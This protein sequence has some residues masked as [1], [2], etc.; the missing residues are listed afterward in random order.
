MPRIVDEATTRTAAL[1]PSEGAAFAYHVLDEVC[2]R[3]NASEGW[4]V[5]HPGA[6][7]P[8]VF[9]R[10]ALPV[11]PQEARTLACL[12]TGV[13]GAPLAALPTAHDASIRCE[14]EFL[15]RATAAEAAAD[16]L[17][18]FATRRV[19]DAA[20]ARAAACAARYRWSTTAVLL[21][22]VGEGAPEERWHALACAL[23][24]ALRA[25]DE[26][27]I[28]SPGVAL[29]LLG[30]SGPDVVRP[31]VTR[32]RA[33]LSAGGSDGVDLLVAT[34]TTPQESVDPAELRHLAM[35]RLVTTGA[36]PASLAA[37]GALELDLRLLPGVVCVGREAPEGRPLLRVLTLT[38]S[39]ALR[40]TIR[41]KVR[42]WDPDVSVDVAAMSEAD[43]TGAPPVS[44]GSGQAPLQSSLPSFDTN[45]A[46]ATRA[47]VGA[48]GLRDS[49]FHGSPFDGAP[50]NGHAPLIGSA[51][52]ASVH[53]DPGEP[54]DP[55]PLL[56]ATAPGGGGGRRDERARIS[57]VSATFD[58]DR[59]MSEVT[60]SS[61]GVRG[62]GRAP[63]GPLAGGAQ[64]TLVALGA[65]GQDVPF[66][67][68]SAGRI[69]AVP[70]EPVVVVLAPRRAGE[71]ALSTAERIG[72]ATG[73]EDVEAAS[74]AAL[75]ALNRF[76]AAPTP[77][78]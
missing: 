44:S 54:D 31:F 4:M 28:D 8:Q 2:E 20:L 5:L 48:T 40:E 66:Y 27:G 51:D 35:G 69:L 10:G 12:P 52:M 17:S 56:A 72:I 9:R 78:A 68:V 62:T 75:S 61:A 58:P 71:G 59:G 21:T 60:L 53:P 67:L 41:E 15:E 18:G 32:V 38:S 33:C 70:G 24:H 23:R 37:E 73:A 7:G 11:G 22:T 39:P 64:A 49:P 1:T 29:V 50:S 13:Y 42:R 34:A 76:L 16:T 65:L 26:V 14:A 57:F 36:D 77:A 19:I 30:N 43:D 25:G 3:H 63:A 47:S 55:P 6:R 74:R 46:G 45:G